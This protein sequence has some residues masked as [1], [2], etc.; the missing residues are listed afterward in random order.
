[1]P[2]IEASRLIFAAALRDF[3]ALQNMFDPQMFPEEI[4]GFH[5]QQTVE[6]ALKAWLALL[7]RDFPRTHSIRQ[8]LIL[9]ED[10]GID[11]DPFWDFV[12]L[13]AFAVQFRYDAYETLDAALARIPLTAKIGNLIQRVEG[14]LR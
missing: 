5:A 12:D 9:L 6:K 7:D 4:F 1:M 8:L 2:D 13:T 10:A 11:I 3:Q 14:L